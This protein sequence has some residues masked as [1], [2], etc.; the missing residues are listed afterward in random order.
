MATSDGADLH[1]LVKKAIAAV[2]PAAAEGQ[3]SAI[4]EEAFAALKG[5]FEAVAGNPTPFLQALVI[6]KQL[7]DAGLT[8]ASEQLLFLAL[9]GLPAMAAAQMS[10]ESERL[11]KQARPSE[12]QTVPKP[13][14]GAGVGLRGGK[15]KR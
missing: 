9:L 6:S 5:E 11:K 4:A 3:A 13:K 10:K 8:V 15:K 7:G 2:V 12:N 14:A 1:P